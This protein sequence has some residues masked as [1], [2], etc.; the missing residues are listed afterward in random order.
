M[1]RVKSSSGA[2]YKDNDLTATPPINREAWLTE[3]AKLVEPCFA[4]I[5][6]KPYRLTCGWPCR[7]ALGARQRRVG[8]CHSAVT[9][10]GGYH[11]LFVSPLIED[12]LEVAGVVAHEMAHVAAGV[13]AGHGRGFVKVCRHIG[14]TE[15]KPTTA[16]PGSDLKKKLKAMLR[17]LGPYPHSAIV[18]VVKPKLTKKTDVSLVCPECACK[19]R[20][21]IKNLDRCGAPRCGCGHPGVMVDPEE[22]D[23][24][25]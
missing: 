3:L 23:G 19:V 20:M 25:E 1:P 17:G 16:M 10:K 15:G 7:N 24:G 22:L 14:L 18:P 5:A 12:P 6:L 11:E 13:P 4:G 21:S 2:N 8:E 9:S